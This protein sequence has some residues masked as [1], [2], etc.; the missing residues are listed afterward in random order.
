MVQDGTRLA[1]S[2]DKSTLVEITI[3]G[4]EYGHTTSKLMHGNALRRREL[5]VPNEF[6]LDLARSRLHEATRVDAI[7][8][9]IGVTGVGSNERSRIA[10]LVHVKEYAAG[11]YA[12]INAAPV[13]TSPDRLRPTRSCSNRQHGH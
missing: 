4:V 9:G 11:D 2:V 12:A 1:A 3:D 6:F 7:A 5:K 13:S 8:L 10:L